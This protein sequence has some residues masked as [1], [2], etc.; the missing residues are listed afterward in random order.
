MVPLTLSLD[1]YSE[2]DSKSI[3]NKKNKLKK[4]CPQLSA[5]AGD[6]NGSLNLVIEQV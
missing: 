5:K 4:Y 6:S 1:A 2:K 3:T